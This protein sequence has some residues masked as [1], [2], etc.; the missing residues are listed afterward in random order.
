MLG[1]RSAAVAWQADVIKPSLQEVMKQLAESDPLPPVPSTGW[2]EVT[3]LAVNMSPTPGEFVA[4]IADVNLPLAARCA[5][6]PGV[7]V[8]QPLLSEIQSKLSD[9]QQNEEADLR[10]RLASGLA[11]GYL[12]DARFGIIEGQ[13]GSY[14]LPE[15]VLVPAG[16]Y[17]IGNDTSIYDEEKPQFRVHIESFLIATHPLTNREFSQFVTNGGYEDESWWIS[18]AAKAWKRGGVSE[19]PKQQWRDQRNLLISNSRVI[20]QLLHG[21]RITSE[22]AQSF[23]KMTAMS[24]DEFEGYLEELYP[25]VT[26]YTSPDYWLDVAF[27]N[28]SQPVVGI[29]WFE[30]LAYCAWLSAQTG[31]NYRLPTEVEWEIAAKGNHNV[32]YPYGNEFDP[33]KTNTYESHIRRTNPIGV[34]IKDMSPFG[35][36]EMSGNVL[37]WTSSAYQTYPYQA[38]DGR[39]NTNIENDRILRGGSWYHTFIC[40]VNLL[41]G[42]G[43]V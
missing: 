13:Y 19:G 1:G 16:T 23:E 25:P 36:S 20:S 24:D 17:T 11:L 37:E 27:N 31:Q 18:D 35:C 33:L 43:E 14:L 6:S 9:R 40:T 21:N 28:P 10:A 5:A 22:Q 15:L 38:N 26:H 32:S 3:I 34:F 7:W 12:G 39:E 41:R 4:G 42:Q 8:E 29:S 2:E 30:A